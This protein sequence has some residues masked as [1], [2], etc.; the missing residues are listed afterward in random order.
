[1]GEEGG[2]LIGFTLETIAVLVQKLLE[3]CDLERGFVFEFFS[4]AFWKFDAL[5]TLELAFRDS[6]F[7]PI[8][9]FID[10]A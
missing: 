6:I 1:L 4:V 5:V 10:A 9:S 8:F 2:V 7:V 3:I